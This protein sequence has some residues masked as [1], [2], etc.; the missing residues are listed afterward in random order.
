MCLWLQIYFI[1]KMLLFY[2]QHICYFQL[3]QT[4]KKIWKSWDRGTFGLLRAQLRNIMFTPK[5]LDFKSKDLYKK[6]RE[7]QSKKVSQSYFCIHRFL[8]AFSVNCLW[9]ET[10]W[11]T[12]TFR[13]RHC[14]HR[15][16]VTAIR[17]VQFLSINSIWRVFHRRPIQLLPINKTRFTCS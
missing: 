6:I 9:S 15:A 16:T 5:I 2:S 7:N 4:K 14:R 3:I 11:T 12:A 8:T 17:K 13:S 1:E 10:N